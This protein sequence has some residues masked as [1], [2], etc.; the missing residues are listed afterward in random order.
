MGVKCRC[1]LE[2]SGSGTHAPTMAPIQM[3]VVLAHNAPTASS[4]TLP[5]ASATS[6]PFQRGILT[7]ALWLTHQNPAFDAPA[8]MTLRPL[9]GSS[10]NPGTLS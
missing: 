8:L 2:N 1:T 4:L 9:R 6:R 7:A 5:K 10:S 3:Q